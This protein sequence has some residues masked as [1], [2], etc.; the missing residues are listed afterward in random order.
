[1]LLDFGPLGARE[2]AGFVPDRGGYTDPTQVVE[3][4][5]DQKLLTRALVEVGA[6]AGLGRQLRHPGRVAERVDRAVINV[7]S[8]RL[9]R[10]DQLVRSHA[11][12][13]RRLVQER[14]QKRRRLESL[15][16]LVAIGADRITELRI[17]VAPLAADDEPERR[18][19]PDAPPKELERP[20]D[21]HDP[22]GQADVVSDHAHRSTGAIP[23]FV[24]LRHG[25]DDHGRHAHVRGQLGTQLTVG[26]GQRVQH[27][28]IAGS[29]ANRHESGL[30]VFA[31]RLGGHVLVETSEDILDIEEVTHRQTPLK[32]LDVSEGRAPFFVY[33]DRTTDEPQQARVEQLGTLILGEAQALA[34]P[35]REQRRPD[36]GLRRRSNSEVGGNGDGPKDLEL[37]RGVRHTRGCNGE[38][39]PS[40]IVNRVPPISSA[41]VGTKPL[42]RGAWRISE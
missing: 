38:E 39:I 27:L 10:I 14:I 21:V 7:V 19:C 3:I 9:G 41:C 23:S 20:G 35:T 8:A 15:E 30:S 22:S 28:G 40:P 13:S 6:C 25:L 18:F 36:A 2:L 33:A 24:D 26:P 12:F 17:E 31:R 34:E 16:Q 5:R 11:P 29:L 4:A 42:W 32:A 37:D 1:M